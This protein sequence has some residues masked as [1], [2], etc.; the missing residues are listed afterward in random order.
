[1]AWK[2]LRSNGR[3]ESSEELVEM[4]VVNQLNSS[5]VGDSPASEEDDGSSEETDA[6]A[7]Q[8][9]TTQAPIKTKRWMYKNVIG[10]GLAFLVVFSA[11][12]GLQ[13]LQTILH[14]EGGLG[15]ASL[16]VLYAA[17]A[18]FSI[19]TPA[20][21]H[22]LGTKYT[23]LVGFLCHLIYTT[24]NF[25]PSWYT[26][27]PAS[28]I[29]GLASLPIWTAGSTHLVRVAVIGAKSLGVDQS[30]TISNLFGIFYF[31]FRL[32]QIPGNIASS[33]IFFPYSAGNETDE[34]MDD[35][36]NGTG[37]GLCEKEDSRVLKKLYLYILVSVYFCMISAGI[38][39]H[40]VIVDRLPVERMEKLSRKEWLKLYCATPVV[41]MLKIMKDYR[42]ILIIPIAINNGM[43][44]AFIFGTFS[45]VCYL[46]ECR[47]FTLS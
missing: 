25:Y 17:F 34:Y 18:L 29:I 27:M 15:L 28:F 44:Q 16:S 35:V 20:V 8:R 30:L 5:E 10:L 38:A 6:A 4:K 45:P 9:T 41:E 21:V 46:I 2:K 36:T 3:T 32:S 19:L 22:I 42:M 1:M 33:L 40:L 24:S 31:I 47:N 12:Q 39:I 23:L 37:D 26:L 43:E 11:F 7:M 14:P 13:N